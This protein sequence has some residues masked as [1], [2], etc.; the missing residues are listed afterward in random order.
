MINLLENNKWGW[1]AGDESGN[2]QNNPHSWNFQLEEMKAFVNFKNE[3]F[4]ESS[5]SQPRGKVLNY[6]ITS[7]S[8]RR[9]G[10]TL[11]G[12]LR[13]SDN[14][15]LVEWELWFLDD[16]SYAWHRID[17]EQ[18]IATHPLKLCLR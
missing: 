2:C 12:E 5:S 1:S 15:D 6:T 16:S 13:K 7:Y 14:G 3:V 11:D 18:T 4:Y 17:W 10:M 9:I 8:N